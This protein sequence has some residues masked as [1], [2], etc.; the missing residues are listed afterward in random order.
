MKKSPF[1]THPPSP[2]ELARIEAFLA[3]MTPRP[4]QPGDN[5]SYIVAVRDRA[6]V[7]HELQG[8]TQVALVHRTRGVCLS[9]G[10]VDSGDA[11]PPWDQPAITEFSHPTERT[12]RDGGGFIFAPFFIKPGEGKLRYRL[13]VAVSD[14]PHR[15]LAGL[16][17]LD[18][19]RSFLTG[20][21]HV[22]VEEAIKDAAC[23][24]LHDLIG[25]TDGVCKKR[26]TLLDGIIPTNSYWDVSKLHEGAGQK[27]A[28]F[29]F[30]PDEVVAVEPD[31]PDTAYRLRD[32][33]VESDEVETADRATWAGWRFQRYDEAA[34]TRSGMTKSA[35]SALFDY[36][37]RL[38]A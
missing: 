11:R 16:A 13:Y 3:K 28:G 34:K 12:A 24:V 9:Y 22:E 7:I 35:L 36:L 19:P 26:L 10:M 21:A 1:R 8:M 37:D 38:D 30:Q 31:N 4:I 2:A 25:T 32:D 17:Q 27:P 18:L 5:P 20:S 23:N 6:G 33:I 15:P 14:L 29:R